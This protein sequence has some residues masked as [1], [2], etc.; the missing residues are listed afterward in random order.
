MR[1]RFT[2][3]LYEAI[4]KDSNLHFLTADLGFKMWDNI[5]KDYPSNF[6]KLGSSEQ[7]MMGM[8]VG[9][10]YSNKIPIYYSISTFLLN[11]PFEW[12]RNFVNYE[13]LPAADLNVYL[14]NEIRSGQ[15]VNNPKV[16]FSA[17]QKWYQKTRID[18]RVE[19]L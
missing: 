14:N 15:F 4:K 6:T 19:K 18:K 8:A 16:S 2:E 5:E 12:L 11:R 3:L 13:N 7:L 1:K 17:F 9:L 10:S